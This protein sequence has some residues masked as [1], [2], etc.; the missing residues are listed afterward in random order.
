M[1]ETAF[2][3]H[4][5][6][7]MLFIEKRKVTAPFNT[8]KGEAKILQHQVFADFGHSPTIKSVIKKIIN[9]WIPYY[10]LKVESRRFW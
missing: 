8:F 5:F 9:K 10:I 1:T 3:L 4:F 6:D 7:S 2:G